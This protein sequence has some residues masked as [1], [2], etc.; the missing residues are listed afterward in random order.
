M[1]DGDAL[2]DH[3]FHI[4]GLPLT[5]ELLGLEDVF[6]VVL[7]AMRQGLLQVFSCRACL[8]KMQYKFQIFKKNVQPWG[9]VEYKG[10]YKGSL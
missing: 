6:V 8:Q 1:E 9:H 2:Q 3:G 4:T 10:L 5:F 7:L